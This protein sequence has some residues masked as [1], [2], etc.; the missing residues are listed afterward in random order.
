MHRVLLKKSFGRK[1]SKKS[2]I[3]AKKVG[4]KSKKMI[5]IGKKKKAPQNDSM[6]IRSLEI[7][8]SESRDLLCNLVFVWLT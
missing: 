5:S 6:H 2:R 4:K 7:G 3:L 8:G 1:E